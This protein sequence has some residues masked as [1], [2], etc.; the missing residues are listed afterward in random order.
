M[1]ITNRRT[2]TPPT[3]ARAFPNPEPLTAAPAPGLVGGT[4]VGTDGADGATGCA[5][6]APGPTARAPHLLQNGPVNGVPQLTQNPG[7]DP[8]RQMHGVGNI[9]VHQ[10]NCTTRRLTGG[11][12]YSRRN[13]VQEKS[14]PK[15]T[16][17]RDASRAIK[18]KRILTPHGMGNGDKSV[19]IAYGQRL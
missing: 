15:H 19:S 13:R 8:P 14:T 17:A 7:I 11:P 2:N 16:T 18:K 4:A 9:Y 6:E 5:V 1:P 12:F 3:M 10:S